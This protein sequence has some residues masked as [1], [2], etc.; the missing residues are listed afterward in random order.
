MCF[1]PIISITTAIFEFTV[2]TF[3]LLYYKKSKLKISIPLFL[4][5]LGF[6]QLTEF[7]LCTTNNPEIWARLGF[8]TYTF[9]PVLALYITLDLIG[10]KKSLWILIFPI[11]F[12]AFALTNDFIINSSCEKYFISVESLFYTTSSIIP[13]LIYWAYFFGFIFYIT[14]LSINYYIKTKSEVKKKLE[15]D[16]FIGI[17][18]SL[19]AA[20]VL[21][22]LFPFLAIQLPSV[23]CL[24]AIIFAICALIAYYLDN[25]KHK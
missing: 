15:I 20:F 10:K 23:Y 24:F 13:A 1:T 7:M 21:L 16:L 9:F 8:I 5:F 14:Y 22:F 25:K 4:Y 2:A 19:S 6:Y 3:I 18:L 11:I 17:F 12:S